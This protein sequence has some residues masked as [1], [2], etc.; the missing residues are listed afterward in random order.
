M[1]H[2][3]ILVTMVVLCL[4]SCGKDG[5][6]GGDKNGADGMD[7]SL[8]VK[9]WNDFNTRGEYDSLI[10][11]TMPYYEYALEHNDSLWAFYSGTFI[12][13]AHLSM[14]HLDSVAFW[15]R[16]IS[17]LKRG[18][19]NNIVL[20]VWH[21]I[22]GNYEL[23]RGLDYS[24]A[25]EHF[26]QGYELAKSTS[27]KN[28]MAVLLANIANIFYIRSDSY[29]I[30]Y[31]EEAC[32]I[33]SK[34]NIDKFPK[35]QALVAMAQ[36]ISISDN[37][38]AAFFYLSEADKYATENG[39]MSLYSMIRLL[40]AD[41]YYDLGAGDKSEQY[42]S[43]ALLYADY[44]EP[45]N[46]SLIFLHYGDFCRANGQY[47]KA[48]DLYMK[49]L[50]SSFKYKN[51]EFRG[52]LLKRVR[53]LY[54]FIGEEDLSEKYGDLFHAHLDSIA[55]IEKEKSLHS[56]LMNYEQ[57]NYEKEMYA[58]EVDLL[59]AR[60]KLMIGGFVLSLLL[61]VILSLLVI[62]RRQKKMY[63]TLVTYHQNYIRKI[64]AE[65][66]KGLNQD[67]ESDK[68]L[69][70]KIENLMRSEN[71]YRQKDLSLD[72][73]AEMLATNRTY[74]SKAINNYSGHTFFS[75]LDSYR[76]QFA[77]AAVSDIEANLPFKKIA[78]DAGYNSVQVFYRAF[79]KSTG[80]SPGRYRDEIK[81]IK[82]EHDSKEH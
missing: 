4:F 80:C 44:S 81:R 59:N 49:G 46:I 14:E 60:R 38:S 82:G 53:D 34:Y 72:K 9:S 8:L 22:R 73:L 54:L 2:R 56:K 30:K 66:M 77:T 27:D 47:D 57:M 62:Y 11:V 63:R 23:R 48:L 79:S 16:R 13:Q 17:P 35:C 75:Y 10:R 50:T 70:V 33:A 42:Y 25:V 39:F 45:V 36:S 19:D 31:A 15:F 74:V 69:F 32:L 43:D 6:D 41:L 68:D 24:A 1:K 28:N 58:K 37:A 51:M 18:V 3:Y 5:E 21:N 71:L 67:K 40:Y 52:D 26:L 7:F 78:D 55:N 65:E 29:G 20:L 61:V 12:A 64:S 76:I